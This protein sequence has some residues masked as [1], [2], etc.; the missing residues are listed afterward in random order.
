[1]TTPY[2]HDLTT[3]P[4]ALLAA[5]KTWHFSS[6]Q[7][8]YQD[9]Q[10]GRFDRILITG[11]GASYSGAYPAWLLLSQQTT[12]VLL[13]ETSELI[14]AARG[15]ITPRTLL[16]IVSQSGRSAEILPLLD[17]PRSQRPFI[18]AATNNPDSPLAQ[19]GDVVLALNTPEELTVSSRTYLATLG[20]TQLAALA[21]L[22]QPLDAAR[23]D[24]EKT[25]QAAQAYLAHWDEHLA[26][27]RQ[28][29]TQTDRTVVLGRGASFAAA[30][31]GALI[32]AEAGRT[33]ASGMP[34]AQ[35]RHGPLELADPRLTAF[36]LAGE[37]RTRPLTR[38]L[39]AD[40]L[41]Y[42]VHAFWVS[43][44]EDPQ[45]TTIPMPA[46]YGIGRPVAEM[47]PFQLLSVVLAERG[48][49]EAGRFRY[50]G[51]VTTSE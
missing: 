39:L 47:L 44:E 10:A 49:F 34:A 6:L 51:K 27:L 43:P 22:G 45:V 35:F 33:L 17:L 40:L 12:P 30:Q 42:G 3:Q 48:G 11:M 46:C 16:W 9:L 36:V 2:I 4:E 1:M 25:A 7:P 15:L 21:L 5:L 37:E 38:R 32:L 20:L 31:T 14:H 26:F 19:G 23:A 29:V 41:G 18:L 28:H 13:Q 24:L 50:S 8:V